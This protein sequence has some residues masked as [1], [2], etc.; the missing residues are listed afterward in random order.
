MEGSV[1]RLSAVIALL[2]ALA[3]ASPAHAALTK[4]WSGG[5]VFKLGWPPVSFTKETGDDPLMV[6]PLVRNSLK[7]EAWE[8]AASRVRTIA[9][10]DRR[11]AVEKML[12]FETYT[13]QE[14]DGE[15]KTVK[16]ADGYIDAI[17][18][19]GRMEFGYVDNHLVLRKWSVIFDEEGGVEET[20]V[21]PEGRNQKLLADPRLPERDYEGLLETPYALDYE[22]GKVRGYPFLSRSGWERGER[23][24]R[25]IRPGDSRIDV[26]Q[27]VDGRY[28]VFGHQGWY[29]ANGFLPHVSSRPHAGT[30]EVLAFGY[31]GGDP[32][33]K[34]RVV[35]E[36]DE[37]VEVTFED[38]NP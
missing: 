6:D 15:R 36:N 22:F 9:T 38:A 8:K 37:V 3:S 20:A 31:A 14:R 12:G 4:W 21:F 13:V 7:Q 19:P 29:L 17:S 10:G 1:R 26:D 27:A 23:G 11:E 28:Y 2:I 30:K 25:R 33:I 18:T 35:L 32:T 24:L 34:A 16:V 5:I